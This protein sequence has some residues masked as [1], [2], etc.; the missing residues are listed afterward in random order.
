MKNKPQK[1]KLHSAQT[2][3][4]D[5]LK[6][7]LRLVDQSLAQDSLAEFVKQAWH[8]VEPAAPLSWN[9]HLDLICEWLEQVAAGKTTRL[10][11][12]VPP[13]SMKSTL[14]SIMFPMWTWATKPMVRFLCASY[15]A[16]LALKHS[17]DRRALLLSPW[18][19]RNWPVRLAEDSNTQAEFTNTNRGHVIASSVGASVTGRGGD[20]LLI[21][22]ILNPEQ[23]NSDAERATALRF[24]DESLYSRLDDKRRGAIVVVEQRTHAQDLTGHLLLAVLLQEGGENSCF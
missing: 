11:V 3:T 7:E 17:R 12:N 21:D 19:Q 6:L 24:F 2:L 10:I 5:K 9:W 22:D 23:A 20:V 1:S 4:P 15:S 13:R 8:I 14:I 18:Y 16:Q